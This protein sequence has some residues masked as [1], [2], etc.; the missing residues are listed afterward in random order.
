MVRG[1]QRQLVRMIVTD[2]TLVPL[3]QAANSATL[4]GYPFVPMAE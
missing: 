1:Y 3:A 4:A 2:I